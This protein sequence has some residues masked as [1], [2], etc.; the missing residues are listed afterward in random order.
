[1][2]ERVNQEQRAY[3]AWPILVNCASNSDSITY[4]ELATKLGIHHRAVRHILGLIQNFC[5]ENEY[6]PLTIL[7]FNKSTGLPGEGFTAYDISNPQEGINKVYSFNW[8]AISNP[9]NYAQ[10]G[11]TENQLINELVQNPEN[12]ADVFA[13][14]R[15]RG[16]SQKI[17][18][19]ALL[20]VYKTACCICGFS[21][22]EALEASHIIPY[23]QSNLDQKLDVRNGL[24]LCS[25]HHKLFDNGYI[26]INQDFTIS[27]SDLEEH[28]GYYTN[29]DRLLTIDLNGHD[30]NLPKETKHYPNKLYIEQHQNTYRN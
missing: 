18:R 16:V 21:F 19:R 14:V 8:N 26:T 7:V 27:Y 1:M 28:L 6:P 11:T 30:L 5:L 9:F 17:F 25:T 24:L 4:G 29:Y 2:K 12:S 20:R 3:F 13:K 15:I 10:E 22:E 23:S